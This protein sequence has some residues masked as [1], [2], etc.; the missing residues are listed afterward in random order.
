MQNTDQ[1][2]K[3]KTFPKVHNISCSSRQCFSRI[4]IHSATEK[5]K[6]NSFDIF[7]PLFHVL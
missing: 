1:S 6:Q 3:R 4:S 7:N 2:R 5:N